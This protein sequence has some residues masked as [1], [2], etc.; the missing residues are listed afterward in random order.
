MNDKSFGTDKEICLD[1]ELRKCLAVAIKNSGK[2]RGEI[3]DRMTSVLP[4]RTVTCSQLNDFT[5]EA[6][7]SARFPAAW[8]VAFCEA[9]ADDSLQR[10]VLSPRL[11]HMLELAENELDAQRAAQSKKRV[12]AR[13]GAN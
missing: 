9:T 11:R 5:A 10:F 1:A 8:I 4:G 6:K 2:S 7:G 3:A 13:L 12:L